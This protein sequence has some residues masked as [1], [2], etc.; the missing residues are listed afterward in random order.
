MFHRACSSFPFA[1]IAL[2]VVLLA[3]GCGTDPATNSGGNGA[4]VDSAGAGDS[5][6][7]I[8]ANADSSGSDASSTDAA[9]DSAS[10]DVSVDASTPDANADCPGGA[11]CVCATNDDCDS[12]ACVVTTGGKRCAQTCIDDCPQGSVCAQMPGNDVAFFCLP[13]HGLLCLPCQADTDCS[14]PGTS[15][16][17]CVRYGDEGGF[18]GAGCKV[19]ADCPAD[20]ACAEVPRVAGGMV[21]QCVAKATLQD[22]ALTAAPACGCGAWAKENA[23]GTTCWLPDAVDDGKGGSKVVGVCSGFRKCGASGLGACEAAPAESQVC[24]QTQCSGPDGQPLADGTACED[25]DSCTSGDTCSAGLCKAGTFTCACKSDL[26]CKDD[27]DICNGIPYCDTSGAEPACVVNPATVVTCD[28]SLDTA[29]QQ[30][31]CVKASGQC[32]MDFAPSSTTC[33]DGKVCTEGDHCDGKGGCVAGTDLCPCVSTADCPD[34][35]DLCNGVPYCDKTGMPTSW[36]CKPNPATVVSCSAANDTPCSKAVCKP[37]TGVCEQVGVPDGGACDDGEACTGGETCTGGVCGGGTSICPCKGD[38]DC[39]DKDDGDLCNGIKYCNAA[40]GQCEH[41]PATVVQCPSVDDT[42]C[43]KAACDPK[44]GACKQ[45][46]VATGTAC[47]DGSLCTTGDA[48]AADGKGGFGCQSGTNTCTCQVDADCPSQSSNLCEPLFCNTATGQC[49]KNPG[50][51][52]VCKT[53]DDGPCEKTACDPATGS[54]K[55]TPLAENTPCDDG[56]ACT[57]NAACKAGSCAPGPNTCYCQNDAECAPFDDGNLCNGGMFC[58]LNDGLCKPNPAT[59]VVCPSDKDTPC[60][61]NQC[62]HLLDAGGK[63]TGTECKVV[64]SPEGQAC[65]DATDCSSW[66]CAAGVCKVATKPCDDGNACTDDACDPDKGCQYVPN[67]APCDDGDTCTGSDVCSGGTC[68]GTKLKEVCGGG[69]EDCDGATDEE[70]AGGCVAYYV[71]ADKDGYAKNGAAS[72]C[73]CKAAGGY[74]TAKTGDCHDGNPNVNPG[75]NGW[76]TTWY[77]TTS[78][79]QSWDYNCNGAAEKQVGSTGKCYESQDYKCKNINGWKSTIP[80]CGGSAVMITGCQYTKFNCA[81]HEKTSTGTQG[82]H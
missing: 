13:A 32:A 53:V 75:Q 57:P 5:S 65:K 66:S 27:G 16:A 12:G 59:A 79:G 64:Q 60:A 22:G 67:K 20:F 28:A 36:A 33:D 30:N 76:F 63:P 72:K 9:T 45:V 78:G 11:G 77:I 48:C 43:S 42:A 51:V 55:T 7:D 52:V 34:D 3:G 21:Q 82:C 31:V 71:D 46:P 8:A 54:C 24:V 81:G 50:K 10:S 49:E 41:N 73:L 37:S 14:A 29:C 25:G 38:F 40:T 58:D 68:V 18:C 69:D 2:L 74:S 17:S 39:K 6:S 44:T 70:G 47:D 1:P 23:L 80:D 15:G 56:D 35:G 19:D 61:K 26:D 4:G 62:L